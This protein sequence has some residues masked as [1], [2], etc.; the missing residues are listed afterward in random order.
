MKL[1]P[2]HLI[3]LTNFNP[4]QVKNNYIGKYCPDHTV[5]EALYIANMQDFVTLDNR[6]GKV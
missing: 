5:T 4:V 3:N 1:G 6:E 2:V